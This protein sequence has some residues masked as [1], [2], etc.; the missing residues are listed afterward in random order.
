M[1]K[2]DLVL[3]HAPSVYDFRETS[4]MFG[5][6]SDLVPSTPIFEMYPIGFS[7][8][9]EYLERHGLKVRIVNLAVQMLRDP[10]FDVDKAISKLNP[11]VFGIDLHWLPH[12]HGSVEVAKLVK[13]H[14][15]T[16]PVIFGGL[17]SSYFHEE[18]IEYPCVDFVVRGD[19]TERPMLDLMRAI[20]G[21]GS[22][23]EVPN[24]TWKAHD[25]AVC[26]NEITHVPEDLNGVS[27]N[28]SYN[29]KSVIRYRDMAGA[30]PFKD[31]L[32]YPITAA[33]TCRGCTHS[34][35][36][37]GGSAAA[38]K[39]FLG[40]RRPAF[41]DPERLADDIA[42][43]SKYIP[44][45]IFVL[46]DIGQAGSDY[47]DRL[48]GLLKKQNLRRSQ[49]AFEFFKPPPE[50]F[51]EK[52]DDALPHYSIE[53]SIETHDEQVR[54]TFGKTYTN[55]AVEASIGYALKHG[56]ERLD[57]YFMTGIP[58]QTAASVLETGEYCEHLYEKVGGDKRLLVFTSPMAPFLDPGS[59]V[60]E[61]PE[62]FGYTLRC[63]TL[64]E[65]REALLQ[66]SWKYI[67]NYES[68]SMSPDEHVEATYQA[69]IDLNRVKAKVGALDAETAARTED[70]IRQ[71]RVVMSRIDDIMTSGGPARRGRLLDLKHRVDSVN[72][73]TVCEKKEL[74]WPTKL[75]SPQ[76]LACA[77]LWLQETLG[78]LGPPKERYDRGET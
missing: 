78:R 41:R 52:L 23:D 35:V 13:K 64:E 73:S 30:I 70:R 32:E 16:T 34:C 18:L 57:V 62:K 38:F 6:V 63:R 37:C 27:L 3:L 11:A 1:A 55:E 36:T 75:I 26:V 56:C 10:G 19:S 44:G 53:I 54:R 69:G 66:P 74:V 77:G 48:L 17:S 49:V 15:P 24:L 43:I 28:Y 58:R 72:E 59:M 25:G 5:P 8:I 45:P 39:G 42:H 46:G 2:I 4:I 29:M 40:R 76:A 65:H 21:N 9:A 51:F 60:F 20:S 12:A 61:N 50:E 31:W 14:H 67:M 22:F 47:A 68:A 7:T 33:L 71:A